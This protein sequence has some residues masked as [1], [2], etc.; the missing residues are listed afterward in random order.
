MIVLPT[1][2]GFHGH[3]GETLGPTDWRCVSQSEIIAFAEVT[4]DDHWVH[5]DVERASREGP[6]GGGLSCMVSTWCR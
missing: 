2:A 5:V 1:P 6:G 4:V 3:V